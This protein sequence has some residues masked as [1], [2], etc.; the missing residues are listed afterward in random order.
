[1][2]LMASG[3]GYAH[4]AKTI[5]SDDESSLAM[6][7]DVRF[8]HETDSVV[9]DGKEDQNRDRD[10]LRLRLGLKY[11]ANE[12]V[13][14]GARLATEADDDHSTNHNF[15]ML[16]GGAPESAFGLD[17]A[18]I[19]VDLKPVWMWVGKNSNHT[20][21]ATG[22]TWDSDLIPEGVAMGGEFGDGYKAKIYAGYYIINETLYDE[23]DDTMLAYQAIFKYG[24]AYSIKAAVGG[25]SVSDQNPSEGEDAFPIPGGTASYQHAMVELG[26][27][28][29]PLSPIIGTQ[30]VSSNVDIST[31]IGEGGKEADRQS[32]VVYVKV[33]PGPVEA[34][35]SVWDVGYAGATALGEFNAD[36]FDKTG[37]FTGWVV[38][39]KGKIYK[40]LSVQAKYFYQEVKND[41]IKPPYAGGAQLGKGNKRTRMQL[42]FVVKF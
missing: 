8:R 17:K 2:A 41:A 31:H 20:W 16:K 21:D 36:D 5:W 1:M 29:L 3:A 32:M 35:F 30:F 10:R 40:A 27:K 11:K 6:Y 23:K 24:K 18:F 9:S 28:D 19:K 38:S 7:G 4:A 25:Y 33:E 14:L 37:N 42:N 13:S 12:V 39:V 34:M 15:G 26:G 22:L